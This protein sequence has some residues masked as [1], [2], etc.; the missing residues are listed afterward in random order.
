[1]PFHPLARKGRPAYA[2]R[3]PPRA[4]TR[5]GRRDVDRALRTW[6]RI[7]LSPDL[8]AAGH[9]DRIQ[10]E[11]AERLVDES[12][13]RGAAMFGVA[14]PDDGEDLYFTPQAAAIV[15]RLIRRNGGVA[16]SPPVNEGSMVLLVGERGDERL[17]S[18]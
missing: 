9:V 8:V 3:M 13:P 16:C 11:M 7:S 12:A 17:L 15:E 14:R 18:S 1:M 6:F 2:P 5:P 10:H 4:S